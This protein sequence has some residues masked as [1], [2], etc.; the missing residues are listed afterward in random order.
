MMLAQHHASY[1]T[2]A[3]SLL[4]D[5]VHVVST[6]SYPVPPSAPASPKRIVIGVEVLVK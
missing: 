4:S 3:V 5:C 1:T 2:Q 6:A